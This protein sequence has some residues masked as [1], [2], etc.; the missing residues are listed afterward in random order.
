MIFK[1]LRTRVVAHIIWIISISTAVTY[2]FDY[3]LHTKTIHSHIEDDAKEI[4][5]IIESSIASFM[6]IENP[7]LFKEVLSELVKLHHIRRVSLLDTTGRVLLSAQPDTLF[8]RT[9]VNNVNEFDFTEDGVYIYSELNREFAEI[10]LFKRLA[11][12][13]SCQECH[14]AQHKILGISLVETKSNISFREQKSSFII[15][16]GITLAA[17]ILLSM[18]THVLFDRSVD[19][20]IQILKTAMDEMKQENFSFRIKQPAKDELGSLAKGMNEMGKKLQ[21]ARKQLLESHKSKL[22]QAESIAKVGELAAGMAHEIKNP[23]SGIVFAANSILR[24]TKDD[25]NRKEIFEEIVRQANRVEQ[26]LEALLTIARESRF[27]RFP[28]DLKPM[29]ER[30]L[31]FIQQ[32]QGTK[33]IKTVSIFDDHLP[34]ILVDN[35]QIEQVL[36]NLVINSIQSMKD[37]GQLTVI[38]RFVAEKQR[39]KIQISDTGKG[40]PESIKEKIFDPFFTTKEKGVGLGLFLCKEIISRHKGRLYFESENGKGTTFTIELPVGSIDEI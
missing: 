2:Y 23:I 28:T 17:I 8:S 18:A 35:K 7:G 21:E 36:M 11:N 6:G 14:D 10:M 3:R 26:N 15:L 30:I 38:V 16:F 34:E 5:S 27:E 20:P 40:I 19:K 1:K 9:R 33:R 32:Q 39:M 4:T 24:E 37:K 22:V 12:N 31:L 25:D 13:K 29:I